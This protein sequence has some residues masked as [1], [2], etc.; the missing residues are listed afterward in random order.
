MPLP[1]PLTKSEQYFIAHGY[2]VKGMKSCENCGREMR[3]YSQRDLS[4]KRFCSRIC[5]GK[6]N[7]KEKKLMPPR[8]TKESVEKGVKTRSKLM[9]LGLI[10]KPPRGTPES[11]RKQ[12]LK[13]RGEK[14][15]SWIKDRSKLK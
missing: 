10:P 6:V 8:P 1:S 11:W 3:I 9:K 4:R 2:K 15:P 12:G 14:N 13:I 7:A 5:F